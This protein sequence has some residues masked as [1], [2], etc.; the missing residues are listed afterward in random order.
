LCRERRGTVASGRR[1]GPP[2]IIG[3]ELAGPKTN[4]R[5]S[6]RAA[7]TGFSDPHRD[8]EFTVEFF[9]GCFD[10]GLDIHG[11]GGGGGGGPKP[12]PRPGAPV[13]QLECDKANRGFSVFFLWF[14]FCSD[15]GFLPGS[16]A[17]EFAQQ[18]VDGLAGSDQ[19]LVPL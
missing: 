13:K 17:D 7:I 1:G 11:L 12:G 14:L 2:L 5:R 16:E 18:P 10:A 6:G 3:G 9:R 8:V 19:R 15:V 4:L